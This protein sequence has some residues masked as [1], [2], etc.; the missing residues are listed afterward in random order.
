MRRFESEDFDDQEEVNNFFDMNSDEDGDGFP[1]DPD[2]LTD[3]EYEEMMQRQ[4]AIN[5]MQLE[6]VS[7]ELNQRLLSTAARICEK[8]W[9]WKFRSHQTQLKMIKKTYIALNRM[10][11][12]TEQAR[13][14]ES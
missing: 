12:M 7:E 6:L 4:D 5:I 3:E 9:F 1:R 14:T 8:S 13:N 11:V 10:L 2:E